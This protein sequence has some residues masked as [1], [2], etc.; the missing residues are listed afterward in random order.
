MRGG[1]NGK[2]ER[3]K[4]SGFVVNYNGRQGIDKK[5]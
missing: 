3:N 2:R 5:V 1:F 4:D